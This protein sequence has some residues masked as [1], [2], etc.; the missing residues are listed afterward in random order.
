MCV[1]V[2]L[3][4]YLS[5]HMARAQSSRAYVP[6][7]AIIPNS[8]ASSS[9]SSMFSWYAWILFTVNT[10]APLSSLLLHFKI[11]QS[12]VV[13]HRQFPNDDHHWPSL[14]FAKRWPGN[15]HP[16]N[17]VYRISLGVPLSTRHPLSGTVSRQTFYSVI[18]TL[19]LGNI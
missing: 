5:V 18:L 14:V 4:V 7:T 15:W 19:F 1:L 8:Q 10:A 17:Y 2:C 3:S 6:I 12:T 11:S 13:Q 9:S 16:A